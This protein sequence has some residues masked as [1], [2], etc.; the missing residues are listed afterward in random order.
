MGLGETYTLQCKIDHTDV[1]SLIVLMTVS[2][3]HQI[4]L[5]LI[6]IIPVTLF[7]LFAIHFHV[8]TVK[9]DGECMN[10]GPHDVGCLDL[11]RPEEP[12]DEIK[13]LEWCI[14]LIMITVQYAPR[15]IKLYNTCSQFH[16]FF[17]MWVRTESYG[18]RT[19][20]NAFLCVFVDQVLLLPAVWALSG[21]YA[22]LSGE[23]NLFFVVYRFLMFE[24]LISLDSPIV[25]QYLKVMC[26]HQCLEVTLFDVKYRA[27]FWS[28]SEVGHE[29]VKEA[30]RNTNKDTKVTDVFDTVMSSERGFGSNFADAT[31]MRMNFSII[32][33]RS[34]L[35]KQSMLAIRHI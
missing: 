3:K 19:L 33:Y 7:V 1:F 27:G 9:S 13:A 30:C 12:Y 22:F 20:A 14:I 8:G 28:N 32:T 16:R 5:G 26:R 21:C 31:T 24:F 11:Y 15:F 4:L 10:P 2:Y 29:R 34:R 23:T 6:H 18:V 17:W 25:E 35:M